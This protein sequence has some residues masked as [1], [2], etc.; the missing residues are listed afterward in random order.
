[1]YPF[2]PTTALLM[3]LLGTF[4]FAVSGALVGVRRGLDLVGILVLAWLT[5]LGGGTIR[6]VLIGSVPP[7]GVSD[8]RMVSTALTAGLLIFVLHGAMDRVQRP[9]RVLDAVG[10]AFFCVSGTLKATSFE[11]S[12][13]TAVFVGTLTAVGGG[14]MRDV[15]AGQVPEL[16]RRELYA[17]PALLGSVLT[18]LAHESHLTTPLVVW[19]VVALV[20]GIRMAAIRFDWHAPR[21]LSTGDPR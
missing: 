6:D 2:E 9:I 14:V 12:A 19:A 1:M 3:D 8:W 17:L 18:V 5:G 4:A 15:V 7:V 11:V 10:L 13:V 16:L 20:F 21:A